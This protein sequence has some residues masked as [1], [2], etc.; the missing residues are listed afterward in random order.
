MK[1][2][3]IQIDRVLGFDLYMRAHV[4]ALAT[5]AQ[6]LLDKGMKDTDL[7]SVARFGSADNKTP[8]LQF[9]RCKE[10]LVLNEEKSVIVSFKKADCRVFNYWAAEKAIERVSIRILGAG[11]QGVGLGE[12][13][14]YCA[15][16]AFDASPN[17]ENAT[18][19]FS[20]VGHNK[21]VSWFGEGNKT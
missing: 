6:H 7:I 10:Q 20:A 2:D 12:A 3:L 8:N 16:D 9:Q 5:R 11:P 15:G 17:A 18:A 21:K 13:M 4:R 14:E 1:D 19:N